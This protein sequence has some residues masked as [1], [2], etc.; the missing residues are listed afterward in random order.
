MLRRGVARRPALAV[1]EA[2]RNLTS[3]TP[4]V[5]ASESL[6]LDPARQRQILD[7]DVRARLGQTGTGKYQYDA[8]KKRE[9]I[10]E[11]IPIDRDTSFLAAILGL[12]FV[13]M[14]LS[15][16]RDLDIEAWRLQQEKEQADNEAAM[17]AAGPDGA[18][19]DRSAAESPETA[20]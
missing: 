1:L 5:V 11:M 16:K 3:G 2:R 20:R 15:Y 9:T 13:F 6:R 10:A 12:A 19:A 7:S 14:L 17:Q 18:T 8:N 4:R